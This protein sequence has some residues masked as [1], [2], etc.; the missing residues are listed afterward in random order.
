MQL[1]K[2]SVLDKGFVSLLSTSNEEK[3]L[4][5]LEEEYYNSASFKQLNMLST[6]TFIIKCPLF[7]QLYLASRPEF[8]F[9]IFSPPAKTIEAYV[10]DESDINTKPTE[11]T[12]IKNNMR[13]TTEALLINPMAFQHDGCDRF[14]SQVL[15]PISVYS[16]LIVHANLTNWVEFLRKKNLPGPVAAYQTAVAEFL[17]AVWTNLDE[18]MAK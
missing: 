17:K 6:A 9:T 14:I 12:E 13:N 4:Q 8:N 5:K 1:N 10:P 18:Y 16:E 2:I 3:V 11:A 15:T 7:V